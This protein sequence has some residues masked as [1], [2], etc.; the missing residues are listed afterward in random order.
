[1]V[2]VPP[3]QPVV[4]VPPPQLD[5]LDVDIE[6]E[7]QSWPVVPPVKDHWLSGALST[8]L[9][10]K[11]RQA[12][13]KEE[14]ADEVEG[15][16]E[17]EEDEAEAEAEA[18]VVE[19][20]EVEAKVKRKREDDKNDGKEEE[21]ETAPPHK[22]RSR[23][24]KAKSG[25][26]KSPRLAKRTQVRRIA[27]SFRKGGLG[28]LTHSFFSSS[29]LEEGRRILFVPRRTDRDHYSC[30]LSVKRT[31]AHTRTHARTRTHA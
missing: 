26:N 23:D 5:V 12:K 8:F 1:V 6:D 7:P 29:P 30:L 17:E 18:M 27:S 3:E 28:W 25:T 10:E 20:V 9:A 2:E 24:M 14:E 31:H 21:E 4:D 15:E 22:K 11:E 13:R 16:E 19:E